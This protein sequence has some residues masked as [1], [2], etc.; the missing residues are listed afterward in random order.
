MH[1]EDVNFHHFSW[2]SIHTLLHFVHAIMIAM[3]NYLES[4]RNSI[5]IIRVKF[6]GGPKRDTKMFRGNLVTTG[7]LQGKSF[8]SSS[9]ALLD[10]SFVL[11][12]LVGNQKVSLQLPRGWNPLHYGGEKK[13]F[14]SWTRIWKLYSRF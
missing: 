1:C 14:Q 3:C 12:T 9:E 6:I 5:L 11:D 7:F 4:H 8:L 10:L 2:D 13:Y